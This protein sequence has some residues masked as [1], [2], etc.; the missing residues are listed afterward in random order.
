[1]ET[2]LVDIAHDDLALHYSKVRP[3]IPRYGADPTRVPSVG[4]LHQNKAKV[5][6]PLIIET[7]PNFI[8]TSS[9]AK[10]SKF[11][12]PLLSHFAHPQAPSIYANN[13]TNES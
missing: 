11:L 12:S 4:S 6:L 5:S 3:S 9:V 1:M 8:S 7:I 13:V 10:K 2:T